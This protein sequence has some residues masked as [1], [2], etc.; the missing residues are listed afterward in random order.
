MTHDANATGRAAGPE[1]APRTGC[2]R[3]TGRPAGPATWL[4]LG[5]GAAGLVALTI[6][7]APVPA[8]AAGP[9]P[10]AERTAAAPAAAAPA[11]QE[12]P[13]EGDRR[14]AGGERDEHSITSQQA[15]EYQRMLE[16][17]RVPHRD[18][19][20]D[21]DVAVHVI[22]AADGTG[23]VADS[24][25]QEQVDVMN[26]AFSG[27]YGGADTGFS[28]TLSDVTRTADDNWFTGFAEHGAEARSALHTGGA[29]TLNLYTTD[30]GRG[31][32]GQSTFPQEFGENADQDGVVIDYR[33]VPGGGREKYDLGH[34]ATHE[35]GHWLGLFH[36]FQ[37]GCSA[38]GDYVDDTPYQR[39]Q[40][41]G[42]PEGND[43][44]PDKA[45]KDPVN[46][47]MDYSDDACMSEFTQG[48]ADRMADH[49]HAFRARGAL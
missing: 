39:E 8:A 47:F 18:G 33:T 7:G 22:T 12:C 41:S 23:D 28:F 9:V 32:L 16:E 26:K 25:L 1:A 38:P 35:T 44:C 14:T 15:A 40:S 42:C 43:T 29:E 48:Q 19:G 37:N 31:V 11:V 46:N 45:G 49:W 6:A 21:V 10:T 24:V 27:G 36:T 3:R 20:A 4:G 34:T 17:A 30:M 5:A 13:P 2:A